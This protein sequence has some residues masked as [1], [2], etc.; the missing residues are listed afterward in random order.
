MNF[1]GSERPV[2]CLRGK[3]LRSGGC[4]NAT[5]EGAVVG[6]GFPR[7]HL[8]PRASAAVGSSRVVAEGIAHVLAGAARGHGV[9]KNRGA[10]N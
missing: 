6:G 7:A 3:M 8:S 1:S 2:W 9:P 4:Q 10:R 5:S